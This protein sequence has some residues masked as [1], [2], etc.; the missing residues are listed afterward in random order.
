MQKR[1]KHKRGGGRLRSRPH[2]LRGSRRACDR[3]ARGSLGSIGRSERTVRPGDDASTAPRPPTDRW[4]RPVSS[5]TSATGHVLVMDQ[6][7]AAVLQFDESGNPVDFSALGSPK[8]SLPSAGLIAIDNSGGPTQGNIYVLHQFAS[9]EGFAPSG[10]KLA[11]WPVAQEPLGALVRDRRRPQRQDLV[12]LLQ[13]GR[14]VAGAARRHRCRHRG[15]DQIQQPRHAE[16]GTDERDPFR[17]RLARK[18]L[19]R[20][21][22]P[23]HPGGGSH[24]PPRRRPELRPAPS[25]RRRRDRRLSAIDPSTDDL[26]ISHGTS[27]TADR[28]SEEF[29]SSAH[30]FETLPGL[31]VTGMDF[32]ADGQTL[33]VSEGSKV[34]VFKRQPPQVPSV[35]EPLQFV[36]VKSRGTFALDSVDT[37]GG[38]P[39]TYAFEFASQA[40]WE[41]H[42]GEYGH[43]YPDPWIRAAAHQLR[44]R[45]I[46][47]PARRARAVDDLPRA[48]RRHQRDRHRALARHHPDDAARGRLGRQRKLPE[49]A[50]PQADRR[51]RAPRLPRL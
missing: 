13:R 44:P 24:L 49:R 22:K 30:P 45:E 36:N 31:N 48:G 3:R 33:F 26:Y 18:P 19:L 16:R 39:A 50:R 29:D 25:A 10:E 51:H 21:R 38:A 42:P 6:A 37:G 11:G 9:V 43:T 5:S 14:L 1:K 7:H 12:L 41:A 17:V 27:I 20:R 8:L 15:P 47:Q 4:K 2:P 35:T 23:L 46:H 28:Y 34:N 40:E 32:A